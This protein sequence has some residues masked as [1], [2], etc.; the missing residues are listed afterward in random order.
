[1]GITVN[2][3]N[4]VTINFPD[5]P[6]DM[7]S[8]ICDDHPEETHIPIVGCDRCH[9]TGAI[10]YKEE[11]ILQGMGRDP[12]DCELFCEPC[13]V[14]EKKEA[15]LKER[16]ELVQ[17]LAALEQ[18]HAVLTEK[19]VVLT[20]KLNEA[21]EE[22]RDYC[23]ICSELTA[24]KNWCASRSCCKCLEITFCGFCGNDCEDMDMDCSHDWE[25]H[26]VCCKCSE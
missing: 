13:I 2:G 21:E 14:E 24:T 9:I 22:D 11:G 20:E 26:W 25:G 19:K 4:G 23:P 1:M 7:I 5:G 12:C 18:T 16:A 3:P 6:S 8:W 10:R 17:Q 15:L